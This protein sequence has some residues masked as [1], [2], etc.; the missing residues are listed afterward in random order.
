VGDASW[1]RLDPTQRRRFIIDAFRTVALRRAELSPL[2]LV[3]EDLHW[4][5]TETQAAL[6]ALSDSVPGARLMLLATYRPEYEDRWLGKGWHR[7]IRLSALGASAA[8][9]LVKALLGDDA[10]VKGLQSLLA[11]ATEGCPLFVEE[12]V[13]ALA[14]EGRIEGAPGAYRLVEPIERLGIPDSVQAVI[15]SR[16]D[17]LAPEGK[18]V[19]QTAAVIGRHV[20]RGLLQRVCELEPDDLAA[21]IGNLQAGDFLFERQVLPEPEYAFKHALTESIAYEGLLRSRRRRLH[22]RVLDA[23]TS[24]G[25]AAPDVEALARHAFRSESWPEAVEFLRQAVDGAVSQSAYPEARR[26]LEHALTAIDRLE[27]SPAHAVQGLDFHLDMKNVLLAVGELGAITPHLLVAERLATSLGDR[28]RHSRVL[29]HICHH[30]W[31]TGKHQEALEAGER[32]R[33]IAEAT[34]DSGLE[35]ETRHRLGSVYHSLGWYRRGIEVLGS[36]DSATGERTDTPG[37]PLVFARMF[38]TWCLAELG[39][40]R[41]AV[42]IAEENQSAAESSGVS[43]AIIDAAQGI[44]VAYLGKGMAEEA[45][46]HLE[47]ALQLCKLGELPMLY[48]WI[49]TLLGGAYVRCQRVGEALPLLE[50][51]VKEAARMGALANQPIR[52][53]R[54]AEAYLWDGRPADAWNLAQQALGLARALSERGHEAWTLL[55]LAQMAGQRDTPETESTERLYREALELAKTLE[56]RPL[57]ARC[58][59][60]IADLLASRGDESAARHHARRAHGLYEKMGLSWESYE[61]VVVHRTP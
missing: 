6:D 11:E 40:L 14:D 10:S 23:M 15:A 33:D 51:T 19:L 3:F 16:I 24:Q 18:Q 26:H 35:S 12:T 30:L 41:E 54:L 58:E 28:R 21:Q 49:G 25:T 45:V 37:V 34:G 42:R 61:G 39:E 2:L 56:M 20:P 8:D 44:G 60:G 1:D 9:V 29:Y 32:G 48:P 50:R 22:R 38:L 13:R 36:D 5:D 57:I 4:L 27:D 7:Q 59:R 53:T 47:K 43:W 52:M 17:R 46:P 31:L 55:L